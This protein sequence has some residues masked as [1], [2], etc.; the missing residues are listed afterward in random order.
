[1]KFKKETFSMYSPSKSTRSESNYPI[2]EKNTIDQSF[3]SEKTIF[4]QIQNRKIPIKIEK[5]E[6]DSLTCGWLLS[7]AIRRVSDFLHEKEKDFKN[8]KFFDPRKIISLE[9]KE[10]IIGVDFLLSC[11][12]E[13]VSALKDGIVLVPK[14]SGF[15]WLK[16]INFSKISVFYRG[17][18]G[19]ADESGDQ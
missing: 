5:T 8:F 4:I 1:M 15:F 18:D 12:E 13:K 6:E 10:K 11:F 9:T 17:K 16:E 14:F 7:E 2:L 3:E 19:N